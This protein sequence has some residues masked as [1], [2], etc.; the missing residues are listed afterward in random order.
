M[1]TLVLLPGMDGTGDL[2]RPLIDK[3]SDDVNVQVISYPVDS[4]YGYEKLTEFVRDRLPKN[5]NF[6]LLG[7]SFSGPIAIKVAS[8]RHPNLRGLILCCSFITNPRPKLKLLKFI[9]PLAPLS[10]ASTKLIMRGILGK[11]STNTL[12][13]LVQSSIQK[14][15]VGTIKSRIFEVMSV[16]VERELRTIDVPILYLQATLDFLV[17]RTALTLIKQLKPDVRVALLDGP[18][19]LLQANPG[20]AVTEIKKFCS[21]V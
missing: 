12:C 6:I 10:L 1:L 5:G 4:L 9:L 21:G 16:N 11:F 18:H 17:P 19:F 2:F 13:E 3:I 15:S 14:V 8:E 7:E 20:L